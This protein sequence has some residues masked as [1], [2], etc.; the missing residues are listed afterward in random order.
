M[1]WY[2]AAIICTI[3]QCNPVAGVWDV[4]LN[5]VCFDKQH[6]YWGAGISNMFLDIIIL[7]LPMPVIWSLQLSKQKKAGLTLIFLTGA[8]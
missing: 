7:C 5:A 1:C 4:A 3:L 8:L 6:L 2:I